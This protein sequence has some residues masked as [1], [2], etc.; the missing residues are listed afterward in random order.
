[1]LPLLIFCCL[2]PQQSDNLLDAVNSERGG[3]HW[4][5]QKPD[6]PKSAED[7]QKC[8]QIEPGS[9]IELVAAE[10][11]VVDPVWID[12]DHK[13]R[14]FVVEY[15]DY[16]IGPV[17]ENGTED[18][19]AVPLSKII[20]LE[21]ENGD[22]RM[23]KRTVFADELMF[24]HSFMPLMGGLLAGVQTEIIFLKDTDGD[25]V[26][27]V[28][29]V[30]FDGF[31]PAHPQM[32]IGCPRWGM[33]NWIYLTY[34]PGNVRCRRPGFETEEPV[35]MPR[36]D[37]RFDPR[38]MKFEAISGMGQFGNTI[39]ND[40]NRFFCT[41]R[42]PIMMEIIP[43]DVAT[44]NPFVTLS[45]RH[46]DVGPSGGDTLVFPLVD[47]KSNYLSHAGTHTSACGVTAYRGD[48]WD[49]DFQH[50]VFV[51]EPIGH[52]VTRTI[53][54]PQQ[55]SPAL[56]ARRARADADFLAST[57]TWFR[58]ASLR[59]GP[60]GALY[61]A[62]MYRMWVEHPKFL[63]P[64]IA[65]RID[66]REGED[67]GRI[68]RIVPT[69][70]PEPSQKF[71]APKSNRDLVELLKDDNGWRRQM[72]QQRLVES[73]DKNVSAL[74]REML[75]AKES[76]V[77][78][79]VNA[80]WCLHGRSEVECR[81]I[82]RAFDLTDTQ[83]KDHAIRLQM[84]MCE[85][86]PKR[87]AMATAART[88]NPSLHFQ[89][90]LECTHENPE[91]ANRE[92]TE[93]LS[94]V[95]IQDRKNSWFQDA[96]LIAVGDRPHELL[97]VT[98][99]VSRRNP[100][101][102][103]S[104]PEFD[105]GESQFLYRTSQLVGKSGGEVEISKAIHDAEWAIGAAD[106][107]T[108][109]ILKGLAGGMRSNK[110]KETRGSLAAFLKDPPEPAA[111]NCAK[112]SELL[113]RLADVAVDD[114]AKTSDR[115]AA[116][117]MLTLQSRSEVTKVVE[118]LLVPGTSGVLQQSALEVVR[119][120]GAQE[121][122]ST[123]LQRWSTLAPAVRSTALALLMARPNTTMELLNSMI[124]GSVPSA[125]IDID[126]R[127]RLLQHRDEKIRKLA[128]QIFGGVVSANRKAVADEYQ[129]ALTMDASAERGAAVFAKTCIKCHKIDGKGHNVGPDISDTRRRSKD[130][131]LYD[132][133]D[134]NRRVDPQFSDYVVV[135]TDGRTFNGLLVSDVGVQVVLRQPE[136]KEQTIARADI[137][138]MQATNKSLMP[139]GVEKD[140]SVQQMADLL[141][142]LKAR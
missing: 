17:K 31:T 26:A 77:H 55:N 81:D 3:R 135:T 44:R 53:V 125:A 112:I 69:K 118:E 16:P 13:G 122:S 128:V 60:N 90:I 108:A 39:D 86:Q 18:K 5:D 137:E 56:T 11:L 115:K 46:T 109:A 106:W 139:E 67:K 15:S 1:M 142:F 76:P 124:N 78:G 75:A 45:K 43:Q 49:T 66:W 94:P 85:G 42:N 89:A 131:L 134:P 29:E 99:Q 123:I 51:C 103:R 97:N 37:M 47:M 12:F 80:I 23:D 34:A 71:T 96:L 9:R 35:K 33:D 138:E 64:E 136:G 73:E 113:Q 70:N 101:K 22:G 6:P 41:N 48:L 116:I 82:K 38:T 120:T 21:D 2:L 27:D 19:D 130:A 87:I 110:N 24:C 14:M 7:S 63:P 62:D 98:S 84:K 68:W 104:A 126:Q 20:L 61:V 52:L 121:T 40:G 50:S 8:F 4:I 57:D 114:S 10:P 129:P 91:A 117:E 65:A 30:W 79:R 127:M 88:S 92:W 54:E 25:N 32:Q 59:T 95:N 105:A 74:L 133:L 107:M 102:S 132:I 141:E 58:P 100:G 119:Q 93:V 72:A 28:R 111:D 140:V 36:Q 83:Q